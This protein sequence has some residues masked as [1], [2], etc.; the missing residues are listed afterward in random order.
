MN[1]ILVISNYTIGE[2]VIIPVSLI[3]PNPNFDYSDYIHELFPRSECSFIVCSSIRTFT[4]NDLD[5][6]TIN[7]KKSN[8]IKYFIMYPDTAK[9]IRKVGTLFGATDSFKEAELF[10][11]SEE[12]WSFIERCKID[13]VTVLP[14]YKL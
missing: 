10:N 6:E 7:Q 12:A 5:S 2:V 4:K 14:I 8:M 3:N 11:T 1:E 9:Y 13:N